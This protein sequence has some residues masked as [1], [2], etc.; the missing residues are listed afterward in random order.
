MKISDTKKEEIIDKTN[1]VELVSEYVQLS[2]NGGTFKGLCPFHNE[3]TPSFS[4]TPDKGY[5]Y[6]FGCHKGGDSIR[7]LMEVEK[8]GFVDALVMLAGK[9]GVSIDRNEIESN[10]SR[11]D[12]EAMLELYKRV[13]GSFNYILNNSTIAEKA[14]KYLESRGI[15]K[16]TVKIFQLGYAPNDDNWLYTF[17]KG[18]NYSDSFLTESG[19]FSKTKQSSPLF[20]NRLIF[21]IFS[22][23]DEVI[24]FSGRV[25]E[26]HGPKYIK[27]PET[28]IY[29]K[30]SQL[31]GMSQALKEIKSKRSFI[32]CEGI[33]DVLALHQTGFRNSVASPGT[34]FTMDH[35]KLLKRFSDSGIIVFD[36]DDAGFKAGYKAAVICEK[37]GITISIVEVSSGRDPADIL[38]KDGAENLQKIIENPLNI[39]EY[40]LER[41][42]KTYDAISPEGIEAIVK[43]LFPYINSIISDVK[44]DFCLE[45]MTRKLGIGKESI[46]MRKYE[47]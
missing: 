10:E 30:K 34:A 40:L 15:T 25:L 35:A 12:R 14:L 29:N 20:V 36:G 32:L 26:D 4:V 23:H 42:I 46:L 39:F 16:E 33:F 22:I 28:L 5:Y 17:L 13:S 45:K 7:F 44:R 2:N 11:A 21:P 6:C 8:L 31:F 3:K 38:E 1:I 37:M 43:E 19:L 27:T 18:K 24:G 41:F 9:A 47:K